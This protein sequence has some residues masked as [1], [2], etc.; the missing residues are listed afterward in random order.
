MIS[1]TQARHLFLDLLRAPIIFPDL[2]VTQQDLLL[3]ML[4]RSGLLGCFHQWMKKAGILEQLHHRVQNILTGT[5]ILAQDHE[6]MMR[7]EVNR[8]Q[9]ALFGTSIQLTLLKGAAYA[10]ADLPMAKGRLV[11]DVDILIPYARLE[12]VEKRLTEHGY[13]T[14]DLDPY[15]L[16]YYREWMHEL[17]PMRHLERLTEVDVH[18]TILPRTSR[19]TPNPDLLFA[20]TVPIANTPPHLAVLSPQDII[21]HAVAQLFV[22]SHMENGIR[23]LVDL[24]GLW[25]FYDT[26]DFFWERLLP[27]A[28]ELN[29]LRPLFYALRY[30]QRLLGTPIPSHIHKEIQKQAAPSRLI[31]ALM[32][33]LVPL[34]LLPIHPDR[35]NPTAHIAA[36]VLF[37]RSHWL[38]MPPALLIRH[39][40]RKSKKRIR[41]HMRDR[42]TI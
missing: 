10:L 6:R 23:D 1:P 42:W 28:K 16:R 3:R 38:R 41:T 20:Q 24:D 11:A 35:S 32:D 21:L 30:C 15:D 19:F 34:A 7:W 25:R 14:V 9:R 39:L 26:H 2:S 29:L 37:I 36:W 31:C 40:M 27:R 5:A 13:T 33:R 17:P 4:R 8:L 18:H 12:E 22:D